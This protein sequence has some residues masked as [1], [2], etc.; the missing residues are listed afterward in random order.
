MDNKIIFNSLV[1]V[2]WLSIIVRSS[3]RKIESEQQQRRERLN[4][5][6]FSNIDIRKRFFKPLMI[7]KPERRIQQKQDRRPYSYRSPI[8]KTSPVS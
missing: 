8:H 3:Q 1:P 6:N 2:I 5:R 4:Q 7:P